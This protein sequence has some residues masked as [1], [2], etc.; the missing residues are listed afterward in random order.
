MI[1]YLNPA[2]IYT[3]NEQIVGHKPFVRDRR[4]LVAACSRPMTQMFGH[5]AYPTLTA[6]AA[7]LL[8]A[9]AHDHPFGDGNKRTATEAV[10]RFV[11]ENNAH[12]AWTDT[13]AYQMVLEIAQGVLN[14]DDVAARLDSY[15]IAEGEN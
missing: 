3:I 5:E 10:I 14:A 6:K 4:T 8:H 1:R 9:L 15:I 11:E 12:I 13:E 7:A 2:D